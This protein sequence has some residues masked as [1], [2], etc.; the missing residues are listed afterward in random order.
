MHIR[1]WFVTLITDE[2]GLATVEYAVLLAGLI[3][4]LSVTWQPL[5]DV[6][7]STGEE[8]EEVIAAGAVT[9]VSCQ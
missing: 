1:H 5:A 7:I 3:I 6:M 8:A 4:G 2:E 9:G